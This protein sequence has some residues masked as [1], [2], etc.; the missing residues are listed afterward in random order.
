M[1]CEVKT[2]IVGKT[3]FFD[4]LSKTVK[5]EFVH[6]RM[7]GGKSELVTVAAPYSKLENVTV[8]NKL[9]TS[10]EHA[11]VGEFLPEV[12][13]S[14]IRVGIKVYYVKIGVFFADCSYRSRYCHRIL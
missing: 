3:K 5:A 13:I 11:R 14:Q 10:S 2:Q 9:V 7:L 6:F 4:S 12:I 8:A 1:F